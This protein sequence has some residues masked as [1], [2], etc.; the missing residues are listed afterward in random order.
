MELDL[1]EKV[2]REIKYYGEAGLTV[3]KGYVKVYSGPGSN[4][5]LVEKVEE[6]TVF[7]VTEIR[8]SRNSYSK[9]AKI[10]TLDEYTYSSTPTSSIEGWV[11]LASSN[12]AIL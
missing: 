12:L 2:E 3:V 8:A 10:K 4:Y 11:S 1:W 6:G 9:F 5:S 7:E